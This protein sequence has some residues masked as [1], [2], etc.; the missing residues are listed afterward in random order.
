VVI[1][2]A[3]VICGDME[4]DKGLTS[5]DIAILQGV[6][7]H[8]CISLS[9]DAGDNAVGMVPEQGVLVGRDQVTVDDIG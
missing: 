7:D 9:G 8:V 5:G 4:E 6:L 1:E 2:S 3:G